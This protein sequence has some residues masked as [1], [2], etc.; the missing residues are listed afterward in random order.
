MD[1][2]KKKILILVLALILG[3]LTLIVAPGTGLDI[4]GQRLL[5]TLIVMVVIWVGGALSYPVSAFL[6]IVLMTFAVADYSQAGGMKS[7]FKLALKGFSGT[8]PITVIAGTAL[9]AVVKS[10]GL[11]KR[12]VYVI[13]KKLATNA[14]TANASK[15][16]AAFFLVD[17]PTSMMVP[18]AMGRCAT[19]MS[20]AE[21]LQDPF[22][23][24]KVTDKDN[25]PNPFQKA[26]WITVALA[27]IIMG[28]AFL[29]GAEATI[30]VGGLIEDF[31]GI[32]QLWGSSFALLF[33]PALLLLFVSWLILTRLFPTTVNDIPINFIN[34]ELI[35]LGKMTYQEKYTLV[36]LLATIFMFVTDSIHH[37]HPA[38]VLLASTVILF[39][40]R[41]GPG[42]WKRDSKEIAWG[43]FVVIGVAY[44]YASLLREFGVID[45]FVRLLQTFNVTGYFGVL[46]IMIILT[47]IVRV[48]I[49]SITSAATILVPIALALG[50]ASGLTPEHTVGVGWVTYVFC[51]L[52]IFFPHQGGQLIMVYDKDYFTRNDLKKAGAVITLAALAIYSLWS[53]IFMPIILS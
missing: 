53:G 18:T 3:G 16:L 49:A 24:A 30:M 1:S 31:T 19:Y 5:A 4:Y 37:I 36:T 47:V 52:A 7:A 12:I 32:P 34:D 35:K 2:E 25:P 38:I 40:P 45:Y 21:G 14:K 6:L 9:A 11:A 8:V 20:I 23:F 43:G 22:K 50:A 27:P 26:V 13:M 48:G 33:L 51:R 28:T 42:N 46:A 44:G 17:I 10:S 41:I 39:L 29:T 15:I